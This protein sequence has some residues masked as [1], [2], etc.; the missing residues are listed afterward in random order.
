MQSAGIWYMSYARA[1]LF[2]LHVDDHIG[3]LVALFIPPVID[4]VAGVGRRAPRRGDV[5]I[6]LAG[7]ASVPAQ[8]LASAVVTKF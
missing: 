4:E 7:A 6:L 1:L 3:R 2:L 5:S 8:S